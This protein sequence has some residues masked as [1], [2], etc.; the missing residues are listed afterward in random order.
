LWILLRK[1]V[2]VK[3]KRKFPNGLYVQF[4]YFFSANARS[5][6]YSLRRGKMI[7][8]IGKLD[9]KPYNLRTRHANYSQS[10][11]QQSNKEKHKGTQSLPHIRRFPT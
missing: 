6:G 9:R 5:S 10:P 2:K 11:N 8:F 4:Y 7:Q 3:K 1:E